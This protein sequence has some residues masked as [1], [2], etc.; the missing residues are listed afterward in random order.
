MKIV[1]V[2]DFFC[3]LSGWGPFVSVSLLNPRI[4]ICHHVLQIWI[5][6]RI[7]YICFTDSVSD[8]DPSYGHW[9]SSWSDMMYKISLFCWQ[10]LSFVSKTFILK[11]MV[12]LVW[13]ACPVCPVI[14]DMSRLTCSGYSVP[15]RL[16]WA[17]SWL[18]FYGLSCFSY[19][20][21][22]SCSGQAVLPVLSWLTDP[23]R[24]VPAIQRTAGTSAQAACSALWCTVAR[25]WS[26][27]KLLR[28][29]WLV[30]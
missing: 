9:S 23:D 13:V 10:W 20:V 7:Q 19:H 12:V 24:P 8:P 22:L 1:T 17:I 26:E 29:V 4:W 5:H 14:A 15:R 27:S 28:Y 21:P 6:L 25:K 30:L 18:S 2:I 11:N 3:C 16:S